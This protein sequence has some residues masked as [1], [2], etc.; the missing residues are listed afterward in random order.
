MLTFVGYLSPHESRGIGRVIREFENLGEF[1]SIFSKNFR[2]TGDFTHGIQKFKLIIAGENQVF[3]SILVTFVTG[4][5]PNAENLNSFFSALKPEF[6]FHKFLSTV[7]GGG[8]AGC[9]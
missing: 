3:F 7:A 6:F 4:V 1:E 2:K 9:M 8:K 5:F